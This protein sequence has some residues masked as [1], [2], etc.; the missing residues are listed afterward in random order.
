MP[1]R[2]DLEYTHNGVTVKP[3]KGFKCEKCGEIEF[4][5]EEVKRMEKI[6]RG[7]EHEHMRS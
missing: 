1:Y 2:T 6:I 4:E 5:L 3:V 7:V